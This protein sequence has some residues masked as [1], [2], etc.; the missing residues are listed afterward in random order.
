MLETL[1]KIAPQR[2]KTHLDS[3]Q[4]SGYR[5]ALDHV[6]RCLR[7]PDAS[8]EAAEVLDEYTPN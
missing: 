8:K 2:G 3:K 7:S 5:L 6:E 4:T 1:A